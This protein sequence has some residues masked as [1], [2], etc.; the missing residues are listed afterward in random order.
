MKAF[1]VS[2]D[3]FDRFRTDIRF[4][5]V[6][7]SSKPIK[8]SGT[9]YLYTC[10][11]TIRKPFVFDQSFSWGYPLWRYLADSKGFLIPET[12]FTKDKYDGYMGCPFA[13][14]E[15]VYYDDQEYCTDEI[16]ELVMDLKMGYDGV[17]IKNIDEGDTLL[18]VDD[19]I[20]FNPEQIKI[21]DIKST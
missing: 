19:Y 18:C 6:F 3:F 17:I 5:Y 15:Q 13:F 1:H 11:L 20:V 14:W 7:F 16:P 2:P 8:L 9:R 10:E 12:E 21:T 4:P